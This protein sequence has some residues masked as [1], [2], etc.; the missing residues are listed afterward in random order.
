MMSAIDVVE[1]LDVLEAADV[2]VFLDGGWGVDALIGAQTRE[3][4]DLDVHL[5]LEDSPR[6]EALLLAAGF[7]R[8][9][10]G[11]EAN[12]VLRDVADR[13]VDIHTMTIDATGGGDY[14]LA[15][16]S[17]WVWPSRSFSGVG[18]IAGR[19]VRCLSP[20]AQV[21]GHTGYEL[22]DTDRRDLTILRERFGAVLGSTSPSNSL[23]LGDIDTRDITA[24]CRT[25]SRG[26][27]R[28]TFPPAPD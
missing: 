12:Y 15:D 21:L 19:R 28:R 23:L 20:R 14:E 6:A 10:G 7:A 27:S 16:G 3:H 2:A 13:R 17:T 25:V 18:S 1:V 8:M 26:A 9:D 4:D 11:R 24:D 22:S 5:S